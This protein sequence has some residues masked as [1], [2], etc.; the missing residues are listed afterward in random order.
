MFLL[1]LAFKGSVK[2]LLESRYTDF[3]LLAHSYL[4]IPVS[5]IIPAYNEERG[6]LNSIHSALNLRYPEFEV[7]VI[8]DGSTDN[9]LEILQSEFNLEPQDIFYPT[10]L[11]TK[12]I[13][14]IY[15]SKEHENLWIID[16]ENGSKADAQNAGYNFA[17]N[18]YVV[19]TDADS[20]FEAGGLLRISRLVN[21]DPAK[22][23]GIGGQIRVGN[24]IE[25]KDGRTIKKQLPGS[26]VCL[27]QVVEYLGSFLGNRIGW[28]EL[29]SVIVLSGGFGM[30]RKD[31]VF[32][33]GGATT[34]TTHEDIEMTFHAHEYFHANHRPYKIEFVPDPIVWTEVPDTW[35][36]LYIQRRRWQ[37]VVIEVCWRY[38][39]MMLN[40]RYG[41][42]GM[43]GI[44]Y[45]VIYEIFGP[46]VEV[47]SYLVIV[48]F[49]ATGVLSINL[50]LLFLLVSF[51]VTISVR[52][53]SVF[54]EQF[55]FQTYPIRVLPKLF[56]VA[57][58]ENLGYHQFISIA[59]IGAFFGFLRRKKT[60]ERIERKGF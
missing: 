22:V 21:L 20:I 3:D 4:T 44:P 35:R 52:I 54:V 6:I 50:F 32:E 38:R 41:T 19:A 57:F 27:F 31:T 43:I 16:K 11:K 12:P 14:G 7:I 42:M 17:H 8:N 39:H 25:V 10:P 46:F 56:L 29:N 26:L 28:N 15:R 34:E 18:R 45:L 55:S 59:R 2:R 40:P 33:L 24:G 58:L 47:F 1:I 13:R 48:Y 5:I 51:G 9:T 36:G 30:W 60:W 37:R 23:I 49:F 53:A